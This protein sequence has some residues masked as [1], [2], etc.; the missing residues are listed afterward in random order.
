MKA[1]KSRRF[2]GTR[3]RLPV[4]LTN[5]MTLGAMS[6]T[7]ARAVRPEEASVVSHSSQTCGSPLGT[8]YLQSD[9]VEQSFLH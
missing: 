7:T 6:A 1:H 4:M 5:V 2:G 9:F 8:V 3:I